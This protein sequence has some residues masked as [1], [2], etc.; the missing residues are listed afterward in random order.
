MSS[1][2][3]TDMGTALALSVIFVKPTWFTL[4][5]YVVSVAVIVV[6]ACFSHFLF[7]H[8]A[9]RNKV[10]ESEIKYIFLLLLTL[11][12]FA[13]LGE[14]HAVLP[15]FVLGLFMSRYFGK[16]SEHHLVVIR[17]RTVA[18]AIITPVF[19]IVG[20]LR[21]SFPLV[22]ASLGLFVL[23]F[24]LKIIAKFLGVYFL[25][26]KYIPQGSMY[27]TLLM[28][29]GLT[30][31][32]IASLFGLQAG[33]INQSQYSIL[34]GVVVASAVIPTFIAQKWFMPV[35]DEDILEEE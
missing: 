3:I 10:V 27:T 24:F 1:T 16:E 13:N 4:L 14:G 18:Y 17:L 6:A 28:S 12:Y 19:F 8:S 35:E 9:F 22:A 25:A 20:G 33:I 31:G 15:A 26:K 32:T 30:F 21:I 23:F 7:N 2:F 29:T 5:F 11:V 34:V